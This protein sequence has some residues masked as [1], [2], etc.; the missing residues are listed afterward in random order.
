MGRRWFP[1][2]PEPS[3]S[4]GQPTA[5]LPLLPGPDV[6]VC[7]VEQEEP[8]APSSPPLMFVRTL[9]HSVPDRMLRLSDQR[10]SHPRL[11]NSSS[12][13]FL[14]RPVQS[15]GA[16]SDHRARREGQISAE[17]DGPRWVSGSRMSPAVCPL[18]E[19]TDRRQEAAPDLSG[20]AQIERFMMQGHKSNPQPSCTSHDTCVISPG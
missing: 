6:S 11:Q 17:R 12:S 2:W 4:T 9:R 3:A 7:V 20:A 5:S 18:A 16:G 8:A 19:T 1:S 13:G 15:G 14:S 10:P